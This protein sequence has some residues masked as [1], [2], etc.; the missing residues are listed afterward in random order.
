MS[1]WSSSLRW[2]T[3]HEIAENKRYVRGL[4]PSS[5]SSPPP[6]KPVAVVHQSTSERHEENRDHI[7]LPLSA[8]GSLFTESFMA[9]HP[10]P[11]TF[12]LTRPSPSG[13]WTRFSGVKECE[14]P[15]GYVGLPN[16]LIKGLGV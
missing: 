7:V 8:A 12:K 11:L 4:G 1:S 3:L 16:S 15:E 6:G 5:L 14:A 2:V 9:A 13:A 10:P